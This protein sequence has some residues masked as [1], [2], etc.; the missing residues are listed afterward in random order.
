MS[1][2]PLVPLE[3]Q[4][5]QISHRLGDWYFAIAIATVRVILGYRDVVGDPGSLKAEDDGNAV[6]A[7]L[8][9]ALTRGKL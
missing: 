3:S 8:G 6:T 9:R 5:L 7:V 4:N 2:T 1:A